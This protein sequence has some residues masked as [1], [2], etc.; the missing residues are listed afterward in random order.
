LGEERGMSSQTE[1]HVTVPYGLYVI[2]WLGLLA[3]TV[4]T[5]GVSFLDMKNTVVLTAMLIACVKSTLVLLYFMHLRF[6][7]PLFTIMFIAVILTYGIF[8]S[9]TFL[10]YSFR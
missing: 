10:D 9:L 8:I 1:K 4:L 2:V 7:R 6:E 3:L 5:V